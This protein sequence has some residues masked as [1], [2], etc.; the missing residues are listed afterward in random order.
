MGIVEVRIWNRTVKNAEA[1]AQEFN[2]K[3]VHDLKSILAT[4]LKCNMVVVGTIPASAQQDLDFSMFSVPSQYVNGVM[5]EMAYRP[6][7]TP[8]ITAAEKS[9]KPW[10]LVEGI[11]VLLEQGYEQFRIWTGKLP[12]R[13]EIKKAVL[14]NYN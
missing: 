3:V 7:K 4:D 2:I 10:A 9:G 8:L 6:R 12:P 5:I 14:Q 13:Q 1:I 11:Q